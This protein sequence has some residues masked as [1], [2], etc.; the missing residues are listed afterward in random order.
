MS[1]LYQQ[2]LTHRDDECSEFC[3]GMQARNEF[4]SPGEKK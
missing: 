2:G 1:E 4:E 3:R